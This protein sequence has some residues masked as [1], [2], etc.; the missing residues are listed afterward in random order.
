MDELP[1]SRGSKL[2]CRAC[3]PRASSDTESLVCLNLLGTAYLW[4]GKRGKRHHQEWFD[5]ERRC[6]NQ[7]DRSISLAAGINCLR[8]VQASTFPSRN[9]REVQDYSSGVGVESCGRKLEMA[10]R[11]GLRMS[12]PLLR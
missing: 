11:Y 4:K 1:P 8:R 10:L 2:S 3:R 5:Q 6:K 12:Y 7:E 9:G